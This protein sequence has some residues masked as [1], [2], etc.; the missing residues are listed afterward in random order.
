MCVKIFVLLIFPGGM[1]LHGHIMLMLHVLALFS[2]ITQTTWFGYKM[3]YFT[4]FSAFIAPAM[5]FMTSAQQLQTTG[6]TD[7]Y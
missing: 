3:L 4:K 6:S 2:A 5:S 1:L 7:H